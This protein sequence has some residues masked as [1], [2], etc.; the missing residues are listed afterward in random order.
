[1]DSETRIKLRE[2][3]ELIRYV[4]LH[5]EWYR[6]L[7]RN[8]DQF[9]Q[10]EKEAKHFYGRTFP[11]RVEKIGSQLQMLRL[12]AGMAKSLDDEG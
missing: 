3:P 6:Q 9:P 1:M 4:R 5:P 12:L 7:S 2:E 11:Q 10:L 8:P